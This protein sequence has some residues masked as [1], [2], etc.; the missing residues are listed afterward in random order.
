MTDKYILDADGNP[1]QVHDL[2]T[3]A[4]AFEK[5]NRIVAQD[6]VGD[7]MVSTV[8]LGL[9]HRH[10]DEGPPILWETMVFGG[11]ND[12]FQERYSSRKEA[13]EGHARILDA[14]KAGVILL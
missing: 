1:V 10:F 8:F 7:V 14:V 3:W 5:E 13:L 2:L 12:Q 9:D 6:A 11:D 4:K